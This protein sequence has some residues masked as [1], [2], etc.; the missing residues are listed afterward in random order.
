MQVQSDDFRK[1][2][3]VFIASPGDLGEERRLFRDIVDEMNQLKADGMG[4]LLKPLG[5]EDVPPGV[6]RPQGLIDKYIEECDLMVMLLWTRWGTP[7]GEY[8]S[9]FEEEYEMAK[10][11]HE[12]GGKPEIMLYFRKVPDEV[13]AEPD[14]QLRQVLKF[15][16]KIESEGEVMYKPYD[17][18][19]E[20]GRLFRLDLGKQLDRLPFVDYRTDDEIRRI[21]AKLSHH[22]LL[23]VF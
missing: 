14:E 21:R 19:N 7:T 3:R 5:W 8:S 17:D 10:R 2:L 9:G 22:L 4:L 15:K 1:V 13:Q 23:A 6:G 18:E 20:W 12:A 16:K 11:L